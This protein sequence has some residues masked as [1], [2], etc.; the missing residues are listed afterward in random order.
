MHVRDPRRAGARLASLGA[1]GVSLL[2]SASTAKGQ[3]PQPR[4]PDIQQRSGLLYRFVPIQPHLPPDTRRDSFYDTRFGDH[5]DTPHPDSIRGGGLYGKFWRANCT[6]SVYPYFYGS[7]GENT[8][9]PGCKRGHPSLRFFQGLVHPFRP[10]GMYYDQG[11]Y[12][13]IHDLDVIPYGP[14]PYPFPWYVNY[15]RGG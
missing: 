15:A 12:V 2:L 10:V 4:I 9:S 3:T 7:P 13:P 8:I 11:S 1:L 6:A 5:A 14:G